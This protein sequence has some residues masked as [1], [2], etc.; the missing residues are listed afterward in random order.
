MKIKFVL[1]TLILIL[2]YIFRNSIKNNEFFKSIG[3]ILNIVFYIYLIGLVSAF[4][5]QVIS[6]L[7]G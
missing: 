7:S 4:I 6:N 5:Y 1:L 2:L 3:T